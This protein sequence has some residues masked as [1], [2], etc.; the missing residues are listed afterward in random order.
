M[1]TLMAA[2]GVRLFLPCIISRNVY[3]NNGHTCSQ[4][5]VQFHQG[6]L[7]LIWFGHIKKIILEI[8]R[9]IMLNIVKGNQLKLCF[10]D[11]T[12]F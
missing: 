7:Y 11:H 5:R 1:G 12:H 10:Y 4:S 2:R 9:F 6:H 3:W 8:D